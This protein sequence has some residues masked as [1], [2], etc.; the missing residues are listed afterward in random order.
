[1]K[2][3]KNLATK[4]N[5][6]ITTF[7]PYPEETISR[8]ALPKD[9]PLH[10]LSYGLL[11]EKLL[12]KIKTSIRK[13]RKNDIEY[14][15]KNTNNH[16]LDIAFNDILRDAK[17]LKTYKK[18]DWRVGNKS[19]RERIKLMLKND[20]SLKYIREAFIREQMGPYNFRK[21]DLIVIPVL[22]PVPFPNSQQI[23]GIIT[24][25]KQ[26]TVKY[27][28]VESYYNKNEKII[29]DKNLNDNRYK[30][31]WW[32]LKF[33]LD[34]DK[35]S[36][37]MRKLS[38]WNIRYRGHINKETLKKAVNRS[39]IL[40]KRNDLVNWSISLDSSYMPSD[41]YTDSSF[42]IFKGELSDNLVYLMRTDIFIRDKWLNIL[43]EAKKFQLN[44]NI[45][46]D[47]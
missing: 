9:S 32:R 19:K 13:K 45:K 15:I 4:R 16:L 7:N 20:I 33:I 30:P 46:K 10:Q 31:E 3:K 29:L 12:P 27:I 17:T 1:M 25:V 39:K 26:K 21:G 22:T 11:S 5:L 41:Y 6:T 14:Y 44:Q 24:E 35:I 2:I 36:Y 8:N 34:D 23:F 18:K 47:E 43:S 37:L 38:I 40:K 42:D 28:E